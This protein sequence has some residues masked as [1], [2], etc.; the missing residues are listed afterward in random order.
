MLLLELGTLVGSTVRVSGLVENLRVFR[1]H[2]FVALRDRSGS[3]LVKA[4][5]LQKIGNSEL[6]KLPRLASPPSVPEVKEL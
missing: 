6:D 2:A 4:K 3:M 1:N 5:K